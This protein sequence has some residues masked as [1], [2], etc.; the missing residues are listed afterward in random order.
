LAE[1]AEAWHDLFKVE[2]L[3]LAEAIKEASKDLPIVSSADGDRRA[4]L[5][6]AMRAIAGERDA[7]NSKRLGW[8]LAKHEGRIEAGHRFVMGEGRRAG[9]L[10]RVA[11]TATN[12]G[13]A[14]FCQPPSRNCQ[15]S[16][17]GKS[18]DV[19]GYGGGHAESDSY[20]EA[21]AENSQYSRNPRTVDCSAEEIEI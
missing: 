2:E 15:I 21:A 19:H 4:R 8:F 11:T 3:T 10:W 6:E 5:L 13:F 12:A 9:S 18:G 1:L 14:G 16:N 20:I 7:V 17:S